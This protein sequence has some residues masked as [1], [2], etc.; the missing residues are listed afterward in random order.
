MR[1]VLLLLAGLMLS[2]QAHA[3]EPYMWGVGPRL[4]TTFLPGRTPLKLPREL[5][6][7]GDTTLERVRFDAITGAEATYFI[8]SSHRIGILGGAI[9][10]KRF[11]DGHII[12][13]YDY[14]VGANTIDFLF[15]GGI[16]FGANQF[17]GPS[18]DERL[19]VLYYPFRARVGLM[20]RDKITAY[21]LT[22]FTQWDVPSSYHYRNLDSV[23]EQVRGGLAIAAGLE[24]CVM[25]GDFTPP[26][27]R[28]NAP[29]APPP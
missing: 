6:D 12:A 16:G 14:V 17:K 24:L 23:E 22:V 5:Q 19:R 28:V 25:F 4:G 15:G 10:G 13:L 2:G 26:R 7:P 29:P 3:L 18:N 27:P 1:H 9:F 21:Q 20:V 8:N 11:I